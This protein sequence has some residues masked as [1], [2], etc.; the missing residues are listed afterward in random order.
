MSIRIYDI[1]SLFNERNYV[2]K[3]LWGGICMM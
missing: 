3:V 1:F 2:N